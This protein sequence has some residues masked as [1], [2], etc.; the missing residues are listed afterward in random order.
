MS[1]IYEIED[2]LSTLWSSEYQR[3][4][5]VCECCLQ[6]EKELDE[7]QK[8]LRFLE[9]Q[10][11]D[12]DNELDILQT[13]NHQQVQELQSQLNHQLNEQVLNL[14]AQLA[15]KLT[16][17]R[18]LQSITSQLNQRYQLLK[19]QIVNKNNEFN[20]L[21]KTNYQ[22]SAQVNDLEAQV[23]NK[24]SEYDTLQRENNSIKTKVRT[25]LAQEVQDLK[26]LIDSKS[27]IL[28]LLDDNNKQTA[29][30]LLC[31]K[32]NDKLHILPEQSCEN[33]TTLKPIEKPTSTDNSKFFVA[34]KK[35]KIPQAKRMLC[36]NTY[37]GESVGKAKCV[38]CKM[39][40]IT[41]F[42]FT[43]GHVVAEFNGGDI[44]IE[45]LRPICI[46]C[47]NDMGTMDMRKYAMKYFNNII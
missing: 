26:A 34:K 27:N 10:T 3:R 46:K 40:D 39:I 35:T 2:Y 47:N 1:I 32:T 42:S 45:N 23:A 7:L 19:V 12:K 28:N 36:W 8:H 13:I 38:C 17:F 4:N 11:T 14:E 20:T 43:C 18:E 30:T 33:K 9:S 44:S 31:T 16:E 29:N 15:K 21:A 24:N 5:N 37:I 6:K 25:L 41:Q 22:L